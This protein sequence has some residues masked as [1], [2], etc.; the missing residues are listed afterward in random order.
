M[1]RPRSQPSFETAVETFGQGVVTD[2]DPAALA[3][4]QLTACTDWMLDKPGVAYKRG[5]STL[6][7]GACGTQGCQW[8]AIAEFPSPNKSE[9]L[10][11][12]NDLN[13]YRLVGSTW[14]SVGA[15]GTDTG[16]YPRMRPV[17][18][19]DP[20]N[21]TTGGMLMWGTAA[22]NHVPRV[23]PGNA[24]AVR[25]I[26]A[27][28]GLTADTGGRYMVF[29]KGRLI[30]AA[31]TKYENRL[32]FSPDIVTGV[33][34]AWDLANAYIDFDYNITGLTA[35]Q[36][37]LLVFSRNH[38]VRLTGNQAPPGGNMSEGPLGDI[39]CTDSRSISV[40][41][42]SAIWANSQG[43]YMSNGTGVDDLTLQGGIKTEW[44]SI[45]PNY[46][47]AST[48]LAGTVYKNFYL[49]T[50][51]NAHTWILD[52]PR[53]VWW[54]VTPSA[55]ANCYA[56]NP[57]TGQNLYVTD[58]NTRV[59]DWAPFFTPSASYRVDV[60]GTAPSAS[61]TTRILHNGQLGLKV[62]R[63]GRIRY[64]LASAT[65]APTLTVTA[66]AAQDG[67][68]FSTTSISEGLARDRT[69]FTVAGVAEGVEATIAQSDA[70]D[71]CELYGL[72]LDFRPLPLSRGG[73]A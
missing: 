19:A 54:K 31:S 37:V 21:A 65:S 7:G 27:A 66:T 42:D 43:V 10:A 62:W 56:P 48:M 68:T 12:S 24:A 28:T 70:C 9:T 50:V 17:M 34:S 47:E 25:A 1:A 73:A 4:G 57:L 29:Y 72:E 61:L 41:N 18:V 39:G 26:N 60:G 63:D 40:W 20:T 58:G 49:V 2:A 38:V 69:P 59:V 35:L 3:T 71:T 45:V 14:S 30:L 13:L 53:R 64:N 22:G 33:E 5:G 6:V 55:Q 36:N 11:W 46:D 52:I 16:Y 23:Y 8:V 51:G 44:R 32:W 67:T 15:F